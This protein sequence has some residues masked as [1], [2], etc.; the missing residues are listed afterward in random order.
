MNARHFNGIVAVAGIE[1]LKKLST[2]AGADHLECIWLD[3]H[4]EVSVVWATAPIAGDVERVG[5]Q[6][7]FF[8]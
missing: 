3:S 1:L 6:V 8:L 5:R 7:R 2:P 4:S